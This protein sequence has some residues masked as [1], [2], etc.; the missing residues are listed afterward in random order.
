MPSSL[1]RRRR[2]AQTSFRAASSRQARRLRLLQDASHQIAAALAVDVVLDRVVRAIA[3]LGYPFVAAALVEDGYLVTRHVM[4]P[5]SVL[6]PTLPDKL[7][8][9]GPGVSTWAVR[10]AELVVCNDVEKDP[11]FLFRPELSTTRSE[12]VVPL[13]GRFGVLGVIDLQEDHPNAFDKDDLELISTLAEYATTAIENARLFESA[14]ERSRELEQLYQNERVLLADMENSYNEL[15]TTLTELERRDEQLRRS[16]RLSALGELASGVA[17]DFNNLLAGILGNT[18]LLL[19]DERDLERRRML[20]VIEQAAQDGATTVRRIQEFAR[21]SEHESDETVNLVD[22]IDG[23]LAITRPRWHNLSQREG[24][25][26]HVRREVD[27]PLLVTGN[28]AELRELLINL[29][30]NAI[31]ALP[32]GGDLT[33]RLIERLE[34]P[35]GLEWVH[36]DRRM[37]VL[38]VSDSGVGI[39]PALHERI[40]DSFYSTKPAGKG[41][42]LGLAMCRQIAARHNGRIELHSAPGQGTTFH[43]LLPVAQ[44]PAQAALVAA[45]PPPSAA[46]HVLVVDDDPAVREVLLRVLQR[47]GHSVTGVASAEEALAQFEPR[48]YDLIFSDLNLPGMD[49]ATLLQHVRARDPQ[50]AAVVLTGW[51]ALEAGQHQA[52]GAAAVLT[53]PFNVSRVLQ[54]VGEISRRAV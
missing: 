45:A 49:G 29:I 35:N 26:I 36:T 52:L 9:N 6:L 20:D 21:Q 25:D 2:L 46:L 33:V 4:A 14:Q 40:F 15:L 31:D 18:Q 13:R 28:A 16:G 27:V 38:E 37:A 30:I 53:K 1:P 43:V 24:R 50:I 47:A 48:K 42:G 34:R 17:H 10:E 3:S 32:A 7:P 12:L 39:P 11:R 41:S 23:A 54:I 19:M 8:L 51:G 22:V 5:P 44:Q